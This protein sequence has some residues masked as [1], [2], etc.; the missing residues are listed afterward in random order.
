MALATALL[1]LPAAAQAAYAHGQAAIH[2]HSMVRSTPYHASGRP[3][4]L[5]FAQ[6]GALNSETC[7]HCRTPLMTQAC[8]QARRSVSLQ[9]KLDDGE[10]DAYDTSDS[11]CAIAADL[12]IHSP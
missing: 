10:V 4:V 5:E 1:L 7:T 9:M 11:W 2:V 6:G 3:V 8:I 12:L